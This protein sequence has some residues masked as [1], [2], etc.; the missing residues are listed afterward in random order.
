MVVTAGL[1]GMG[2][3]Q[4]LAV[5]MNGG[6]ALVVEVDPSRIERRL[7]TRYVD[8]RATNLD[9][10]LARIDRYRRDADRAIDCAGRECR[11]RAARTRAPRDSFPTSSPIRRLRTTR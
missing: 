2:G 10:A 6:I 9:D 3:A 5:T 1:G 4:P 11:R 7:A 8:E